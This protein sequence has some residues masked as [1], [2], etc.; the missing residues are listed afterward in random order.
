MP[1][2]TVI[3]AAKDAAPW[4]PECL[5]SVM[6]QR[7]PQGWDVGVIVGI[8]ACPA[9]LAAARHIN[10]PRVAIRFFPEHVGPYII[11]NSL[12]YSDQSDVLVRFDADDIMLQGYLWAQLRLLESRMAPTIIQTWSIYV[13]AQLRSCVAP[14]ADGT[15]T[16][17]DGRRSRPSDGQ[18]LM[19]RSAFDRLGSFRGW[20]CHA[21]SEFIRRARWSGVAFKT[22]REYLYL[23][24]VHPNS[25]TISRRSGYG[26]LLRRKFTEDIEKACKRYARGETP[27]CVLPVVARY[28]PVD[29]VA[30]RRAAWGRIPPC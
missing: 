21:D 29:A 9:T 19:T 12:A 1:T 18:F 20:L 28:L 27:E 5:G 30:V 3:I 24:R 7:T 10:L 6:S 16:F 15:Y 4:L 8:D 11:F 2:A 17:P 25:L 26:S 22:V 14:L 23:R 13:D